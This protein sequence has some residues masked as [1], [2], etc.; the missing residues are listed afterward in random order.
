M[1]T[2]MPLLLAAAALPGCTVFG[3]HHKAD[4]PT[5]EQVDVATATSETPRPARLMRISRPIG[6]IPCA[7]GAM[8]E[9]D[10]WRSGDRHFLNENAFPLGIEENAPVEAQPAATRRGR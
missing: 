2:R 9:R 8:H 4:V 1:L 7:S 6:L 3:V 10:C 5:T